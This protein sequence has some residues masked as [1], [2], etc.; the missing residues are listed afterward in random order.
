MS[1]TP[2]VSDDASISD[3]TERLEEIIAQLED[4]E[5]SLERAN[6]LHNEGARLLEELEEELDIGEG[7][8]VETK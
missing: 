6:E 4:G 1:E 5:V 3:K 2:E 8:V 7:E